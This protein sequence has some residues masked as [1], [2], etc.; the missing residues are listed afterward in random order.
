MRSL[1]FQ[2]QLWTEMES[3]KFFSQNFV[4]EAEIHITEASTT[5]RAY[6]ILGAVQ[7]YDWGKVGTSSK[8]AQFYSKQTGTPIDEAKPYAG[9]LNY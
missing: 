8:V 7:H 5:M 2:A 1:S 6:K 9:N 3:Q 4:R